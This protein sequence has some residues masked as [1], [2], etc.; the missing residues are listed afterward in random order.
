M[1]IDTQRTVREI[2][3]ERPQAAAV[4]E[5]LGIDYC[6]G[7]GKPLASACEGAGV[8][9]A[10]VTDLLEQATVADNPGTDAGNWTEQS[11]ASLIGHIVEKH[12]AYCRE[13][14]ARLQPL[15]AKVVSKHGEHHP[16]LTQVQD[17]FTSLRNELSTHLMKEEQVLFPY[18]LALEDSSSRK[19]ISPRAPFGTVQNPVRMMVQEHDNAGQLL[20]QIRGVTRNFVVPEDACASFKAL[21]Q[22]L[23]AF[24][25]DLHQHIHLENNLLFQRAIALEEA[26]LSA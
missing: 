20:K 9:V 15:L 24:E 18:I 22:G 11:L 3:L 4:F 7:G 16:E 23:E 8:G 10:Q 14:G 6:C 26:A 21:Y 1:S 13:E 5:K 25:A 2:A 12:H 19:S 17:L